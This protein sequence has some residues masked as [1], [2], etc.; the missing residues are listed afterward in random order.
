MYKY[1]LYSHNLV[2]LCVIRAAVGSLKSL[3]EQK[4]EE[5]CAVTANTFLV[6]SKEILINLG[7]NFFLF[8]S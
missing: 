6:P 8:E 1:F 3:T 2:D 5:L 4:T 7:T